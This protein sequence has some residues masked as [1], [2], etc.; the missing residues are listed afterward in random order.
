M[1]CLAWSWVV[2]FSS[3]PV[4][5]SP[6][7]VGVGSSWGSR[8]FLG[9]WWIFRD[10]GSPRFSSSISPSGFLPLGVISKIPLWPQPCAVHL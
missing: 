9:G 6:S 7:C 8:N 10:I 1:G 4:L 3:P 5:S 2:I